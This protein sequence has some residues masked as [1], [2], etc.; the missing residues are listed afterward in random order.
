MNP[1]IAF[2]LGL[3]VGEIVGV[4]VVCLCV[5]ARGDRGEGAAPTE[6]R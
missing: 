1:W 6:A 5:M 4:L 2:G 3:V